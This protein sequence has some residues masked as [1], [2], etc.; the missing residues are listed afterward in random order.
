MTEMTDKSGKMKLT[1][2]VEV[3]EQLMDVVKEAMS[4][5]SSKLPEMMKRGGSE[6]KE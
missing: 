1:V 6:A 4:K 3:N 5:A 2:E